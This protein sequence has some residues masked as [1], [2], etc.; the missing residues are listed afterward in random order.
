MRSLKSFT[1]QV[2]DP[3]TAK[4]PVERQVMRIIT[5]GTLT[6]AALLEEKRDCVLLALVVHESTLGLAWLNLAA[7]QFRVLETVPDNLASELERLQPAEIL[8]PEGLD[9]PVALNGVG[10]VKRLPVWQFDADAAVRNLARQ[11]ETRDL[12][13][14]GCDGLH[15]ALGAAGAL[16]EYARLTQGAAIV[17]IKA[18]QV[19]RDSAYVRMDAATRRN[20]EI[21]ETIRGEAAPTLLALLDTCST[22]MGSRLLRQWLHHPLRD[23]TAVQQRLD[24]VSGLIGEAGSGPYLAVRECFRRVADIERI[25]AR[26]ALRSARP[27]D[28][29]GLR[30]SLKRLPEVISALAACASE[31]IAAL[32]PAMAA[33]VALVSL[34]E[35]SLRAEPSV[36]LR[37]G[38]VIAHPRRF[39]GSWMRGCLR[40]CMTASRI[41]QWAP[42]GKHSQ[43]TR[44]GM[45][46]PMF[47]RW[48]P[49]E[50]AV[51]VAGSDEIDALPDHVRA[52]DHHDWSCRMVFRAGVDDAGHGWTD[53]HRISTDRARPDPGRDADAPEGGPWRGHG[54]GW[55]GP[56]GA[57]NA[58]GTGGPLGWN[59]YGCRRK[60]GAYGEAAPPVQA[61][62]HVDS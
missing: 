53:A 31:H 43:T 50:P 24:G 36:V 8:L 11:F 5:P 45:R 38:G 35:K 42:G 6:D 61:D 30:D 54:L 59:G 33:D 47:E 40:A 57:S 32:T 14:F 1:E 60:P 16:L 15:P 17:H 7:G 41:R 21:S 18:L 10:A 13:G 22:N 27:R 20:L 34:L 48:L 37:E 52:V 62:G 56:G 25:T 55:P 2:G 3:A 46:S 58:D 26:I 39:K 44:F 23:R 12:A 9:I 49:K 19:E 51:W 4:G 29:S 28:L